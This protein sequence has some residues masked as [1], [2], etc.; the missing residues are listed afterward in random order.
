[1]R[2]NLPPILIVHGDKD[3]QVLHTHAVKLHQALDKAGVPNELHTVV[4]GGHGRFTPEQNVKI[5]ATIRSFLS[6]HGLTA[7]A[8][9]D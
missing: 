3:D 2:P 6:R 4:G 9:N 7:R 1:V 5:W 8:T